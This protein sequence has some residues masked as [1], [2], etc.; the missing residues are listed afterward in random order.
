MPKRTRRATSRLPINYPSIPDVESG[1]TRYNE[2]ELAVASDRMPASSFQYG[3]LR[4]DL[5]LQIEGLL[6]RRCPLPEGSAVTLSEAA[7][8]LLVEMLDDEAIRSQETV[9]HRLIAFIGEL[10]V[11]RAVSPLSDLLRDRASNNLTKAHAAN[12]LGRIGESAAL[13]AL[14]ATSNIKD[15]MVRRQVAIAL[16]RINIDAVI[17]HLLLLERDNSIAVAEV[18]AEAL[19]SWE[20]RLGQR[21]GTR[22]KQAKAKNIRRKIMPP[23][24]RR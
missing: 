7:R 9:F 1:P 18:A 19:Q 11:R 8:G 14:V 13:G 2:A 3:T 22:S 15:V 21:L 17:P 24:D 5:R 23:E 20:T 16:G 10:K 12:A 4:A 6:L